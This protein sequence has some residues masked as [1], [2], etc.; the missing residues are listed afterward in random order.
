M[1]LFNAFLLKTLII[2]LLFYILMIEKKIL[3]TK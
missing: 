2:N 1:N 3:A